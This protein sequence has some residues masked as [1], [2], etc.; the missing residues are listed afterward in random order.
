[1]KRS[2]IIPLMAVAFVAGMTLLSCD[3]DEEEG[4]GGSG[5]TSTGQLD[6]RHGNSELP[7][8]YSISSVG[9]YRYYYENG[10]LSRIYADGGYI[11][12]STDGINLESEDGDVMKISFNGK[13][14]VSKVTTTSKGRGSNYSW[15]ES[16]SITFSYNSNNQISSF[17]GSWKES[18]QQYGNSYNESGSGTGSISYS[19]QV[20]QK[21]VIKSSFSGKEDNDKYSGS[22]TYTYTF[23]FNQEY[24]NLYGQWTPHLINVLIEDGIFEALAY[25]GCLGR[26]TSKLPTTIHEVEIEVEDGETKEDKDSY[27]CSYSF[28]TY[29]AISQA[30]GKSYT[31]TMVTD[32]EYDVKAT[33]VASTNLLKPFVQ[34]KRH[35][36]LS[37]LRHHQRN[38]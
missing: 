8:G 35:G 7:E 4:G 28:N 10:K 31:Y 25:T 19:G 11:D 38:K 29:G 1:M 30:D 37:S 2:R 36:I 34:Q 13:G 6:D 32:D 24:E 23:D 16:E 20:I 26:A 27:S 21:V 5:K 15:K 12:F 18:A 33:R 3:K 22:E 17:S 9:N 14:L